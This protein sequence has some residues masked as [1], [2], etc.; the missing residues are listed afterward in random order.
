MI[1]S[2]FVFLYMAV[3]L[4]IG[5][6]AGRRATQTG[7]D[8]FLAS[9]SLG[10]FVFLVSLFGTHMTAFAILGSSGRAFREGIGV[11]GLMASSS[12]IVVPLLLVLL[13]ARVWQVGKRLGHKTPVQMFRDRWEMGHGG[14]LIFAL[15]AVLLVPYIVIGVLGGGTALAAL[16]GG[17]IPVWVGGGLVALVVMSY[18]FCG[19][20]RGTA[21]VNTL[22]TLL[23]L[24]FGLAACGV[25][26]QSLGGFAGAVER[27]LEQPDTAPL[28]T[29]EKL[30]PLVF[31][32][33]TFI[34][35]SAIAFPHMTIFC[36]T[37]RRAAA[38]RRTAT[39][40]PVCILLV[41]L[42]CVFL[43]T[44]A[45]A[46]P[47]VAAAARASSGGD[48]VMILLLKAHAPAWLAGLLG[49]GILA[50]VMA[51]D[52]Q[53][54]ALSTMFTEDVLA[55]YGGREAFGER[56]QVLAG[57]SFVVG[58][59]IVAYAIAMTTRQQIFD[60]AVK[61]AF[62]GFAGLSPLVAAV[63]WRRSTRAG[64]LACVVVVIAGLAATAWLESAFPAPGPIWSAGGMAVVSRTPGGIACLGG[65][66]PVVPIVL[67]SSAALVLVSLSTR[68]PGAATLSRYF[69]A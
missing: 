13:G 17:S 26:G 40:Y 18:V 60:L 15:Q 62:T 51:S 31:L 55:Y 27:L 57:R 52:S 67:A 22:Q 63:F 20:M 65:F 37:A 47:Q 41:W 45:N 34:P 33:F 24:A 53:I 8:Y 64:A 35:L 5:L 54:L 36:L 9:R 43:G 58:V 11:Y 4:G 61:H 59:T 12:A 7:E 2:V 48:D 21:W 66:L 14:T 6:L 69:P 39:L 19:G 29:R 46:D 42:P 10:T 30:N 38:F 68:P 28:L 56:A 44:I 1:E 16:S 49:A 25:I 3:V 50:A 23:F 32:S